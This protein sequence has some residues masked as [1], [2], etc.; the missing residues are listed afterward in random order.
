MLEVKDLCKYYRNKSKKEVR[1]VDG[2]SF[3]V[4]SEEIVGLLGPNG[5]GK[6]TT[7][8]CISNLIIPDKGNIQ[9]GDINIKNHR[10]YLKNIGALYEG[11]R[12]VYWRL[13]PRENVNFFANING[14]SVSEIKDKREELLERF[15]LMDKANTPVMELSKGMQRKVGIIAA[16]I[17]GASVLLLDE[18]TL[19]LDVT[20][21]IELENLI[22]EMFKEERSKVFLISSHNMR[23][24]KNVCDRII[25]INNGR[26]VADD[27]VGNLEKLFDYNAY[28]ITFD[29]VMDDELVK[30]LKDTHEFISIDIV[31]GITVVTYEVKDDKKLFMLLNQI[32][33]K[34]YSLS[35]LNKKI[36]DL[37]EIFLKIV[38]ERQ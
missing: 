13:T 11:S 14:L 23:F 21:R 17:K 32:N 9:I 1:A 10:A 24:I 38:E 20:S 5:A 12:N 18:P 30:E 27:K 6:T 16:F 28:E 15:G 2:V 3:A 8:K 34:G 29:A 33:K 26:V 4:N 31:D 7:I 36:P 25:I 37:E 35:S 19:G 22:K